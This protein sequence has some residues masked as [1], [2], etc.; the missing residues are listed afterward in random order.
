MEAAFVMGVAA[1][2]V[3]GRCW[4]HLCFMHSAAVIRVLGKM[5]IRRRWGLATRL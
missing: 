2:A 1:A 5:E 3:D 4:S